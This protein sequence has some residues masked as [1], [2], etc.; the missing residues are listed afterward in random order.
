MSD[1]PKDAARDAF[2]AA[3]DAL[4]QAGGVTTAGTY[5]PAAVTLSAPV[6]SPPGKDEA[7]GNR[8]RARNRR[9]RE[10][11]LAPYTEVEQRDLDAKA[12]FGTKPGA[13]PGTSP[14]AA[15]AR[16]TRDG[17]EAENATL[18]AQLAAYRDADLAKATGATAGMVWDIARRFF[19]RED[20]AL[21][22][23]ETEELGKLWAPVLGPH[24]EKV[25]HAFP[26][27]AAVAGT[28]QVIAPR[29][30]AA[31]QPPAPERPTVASDAAPA[32][33]PGTPAKVEAPPVKPAKIENEGYTFEMGGGD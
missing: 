18:K 17:L 24:M 3:R 32:P 29:V 11:G 15:P 6:Q 10:K 26:I 4:P 12:G 21:T 9:R 22:A 2:A 23:S 31:M 14:P 13:A 8:W 7:T 19:P 16:V 30:L 33:A 20:R 5:Q 27:A 28:Y 25:A 1:A